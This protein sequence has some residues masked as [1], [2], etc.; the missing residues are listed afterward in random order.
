MLFAPV[1]AF[2]RKHG[3]FTQ[4]Q[5]L[6][7]GVSGGPDSL[8]LL[9]LLTR[10]RAEYDLLLPSPTLIMA[11]DRVRMT[12]LNLWLR[13][14]KRG[15]CRTVGRADV[16]AIAKGQRLSVEGRA[17]A[18]YAFFARLAPAAAVLPP[19]IRPRRC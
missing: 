9:H 5:R 15:T 14:R 17:Q 7:A 8:V 3:L 19:A 2:V 11:Y 6:V 18:R 1:R 12:M 4:G 10:L 13:L 16:A